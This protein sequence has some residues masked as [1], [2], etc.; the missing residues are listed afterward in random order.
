M[1]KYNLGERLG[2]GSQ[3]EVFR[4]TPV[5][6]SGP[7]A[8]KFFSYTGDPTRRSEHLLRFERETRIQSSLF[9]PNILP[10]LAIDT[11][12]SRPS[13]VMPL[14]DESLR[15][16]LMASPGGIGKTR[17]D[18][19]FPSILEAVAHA[20]ANGV[21]HRDIK[22]E[23]ILF[24]AGVPLVADFG[25]G[26]RLF[27][28]STLT[29]TQGGLG[30]VG[31][32]APEQWEDGHLADEKADVYALG[33]VLY[34]VLCGRKFA[35]GP[36]WEEVPAEYRYLIMSATSARADQRLSTVSEFAVQFGWASNGAR[37]LLPPTEEA[38]E[39]VRRLASGEN[40]VVREL[41]T[42]LI[43]NTDDVQLYLRI[44]PYLAEDV[45]R[46][47]ATDTENFRRVI[48]QFDL[49]AN[50][51]HPWDFTDRIAIFM[52]SVFRA[53]GDLQIRSIVLRRLL[54]IG[55]AH[56]RFFVREKYVEVVAIAVRFPELV[57]VVAASL[58][59]NDWAIAFNRQAL[60]ELSLPPMLRGL[61]G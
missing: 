13:F 33:C 10:V 49:Y 29:V 52:S 17:V 21:I 6:G 59:E 4:A 42:L 11:E 56:N 18:S 55:A 46:A 40:G 41:N 19:I 12:A 26:R 2:L 31:Y 35:S 57:P 32:A 36:R 27:S 8:I 9:H 39:L 48:S 44:I 20:H 16:L 37:T 22:P 53:T 14:A 3:G 24:I 54:C 51:Q 23:N 61:L 34:E 1:S 28:D 5:G 25:L 47:L 45:V 58:R 30:T 60:L 7:V 50:D 15:D 43:T 38:L